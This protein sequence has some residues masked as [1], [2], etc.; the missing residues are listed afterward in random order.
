MI[1]VVRQSFTIIL[2][3]LPLGPETLTDAYI[4][5]PETVDKS[6]HPKR[7]SSVQKSGIVGANAIF[8]RA[9]SNGHLCKETCK[10]SKA[11]A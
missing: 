10:Y 5:P 4:D 2:I 8:V 9:M 6:R 11:F 1:K 7:K 3:L